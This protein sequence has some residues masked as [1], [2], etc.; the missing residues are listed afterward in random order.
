MGKKL[1]IEYDKIGDILYVYS[2]TPYAEQES[3][4]LGNNVVARYHPES[5]ELECLEILWFMRRMGEGKTLE[6]PVDA[7]KIPA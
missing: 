5:G 3:T 6:I 1:T 7:F 2:V 4:E